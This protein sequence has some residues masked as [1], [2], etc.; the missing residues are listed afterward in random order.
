MGDGY[1]GGEA[2]CRWQ[3]EASAKAYL[4]LTEGRVFWTMLTELSSVVGGCSYSN[5]LASGYMPLF[6]EP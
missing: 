1:S 3:R 5:G 6:N 2:G 4:S